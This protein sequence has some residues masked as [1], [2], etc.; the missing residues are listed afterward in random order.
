MLARAF[1][2]AAIGLVCVRVLAEGNALRKGPGAGIGLMAAST[3]FDHSLSRRLSRAE[4]DQQA[5]SSKRQI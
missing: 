1:L 5:V 4:T 2:D 3:I